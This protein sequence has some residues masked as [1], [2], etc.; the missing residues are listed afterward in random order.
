MKDMN[1]E[2][3][4]TDDAANCVLD[5]EGRRQGM[6]I[7]GTDGGRMVFRAITFQDGK[8]D[9]G[10]GL[11]MSAG[12]IVDIKL[13]VFL[14]CRS[15]LSPGGGGIY[16]FNS[17]LNVYGTTFSENTADNGRGADIYK[18]SPTDSVTIHDTCPSPY[19]S[20]TP[21]RGS[22][23]DY[24]GTNVEDTGHSYDGCIG[25]PC[26]ASSSPSDDGISSVT[27]NFYCI[28]SG[29][30]LGYSPW[31]CECITC[32]T[33][34]GG[35]NCATCAPGYRGD[36]Y[37]DADPCQATSNPGDDG[38][39]GDF[40]CINGGIVGGTTG[41]CICKSCSAGYA[42]LNCQLTANTV[43]YWKYPISGFAR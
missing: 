11:W 1:G 37:C 22:V 3:R 34:F 6:Y 39:N 40:Y 43:N 7:Y 36:G 15:T 41:V 2:L 27:G 13:C 38:S 30:V 31:G 9:V 28:N 14:G 19:S 17:D 23:L 35:S 12:A 5:G 26:V 16:V 8:A 32:G 33:G 4:C 24:D 25:V 10:A 20:V 42:G 21:N 18:V 29:T